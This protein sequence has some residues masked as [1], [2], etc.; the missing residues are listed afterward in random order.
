MKSDYRKFL[1]NT[2]MLYLMQI[3][4]YLFPL[5]TFPYLTRVLEP[6]NYGIIVYI[7]SIMIYF[8]MLV[9]FG[10]LLYGIKECAENQYDKKKLGEIMYGIT[11][12]KIVLWV[13]GGF[14]LIGTSLFIPILQD[15]VLL[16]FLFYL[17]MG[18]SALLPDFLFRGLEVMRI[19]TYRSIFSK[20]LYT[21]IVFACI[22]KPDDF[23]YIPVINI[24]TNLM[25]LLWSFYLA[26]HEFKVEFC[27][28]KIEVVWPNIKG[29]FYFFVSRI[30]TTAY[31][32]SNIFILGFYVQ[33]G[34][35]AQYG[36]ANNIIS[37]MRSFFSPIADAIYPYMLNSKNYC[38]VYKIILMS[39]PC[40]TIA[41]VLVSYYAH[42]II[43]LLCGKGYEEAEPLLQYMTPLIVL[44]LPIYLLGYPM[45]GAMNK[46]GR[47]NISV[48]YAS[49]FHIVGLLYLATTGQITFLSVILLTIFTECIV[50]FFRIYYVWRK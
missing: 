50:L 15:K 10:F 49:L 41:T 37:V 30:A 2:G 48:I 14:I 45:L 46:I 11:Y 40:I 26:D 36:V 18:I 12:A 38:F 3:S 24:F 13:I 4:G 5:F 44:T 27:A 6:T 19:L 7:T 20:A 32:A 47:A 1:N 17:G 21:L 22:H 23:I 39:F 31:S 33:S 28:P 43:F 16:C 25:I 8:Q 9:D 29:S 42:E 35:L 34:I